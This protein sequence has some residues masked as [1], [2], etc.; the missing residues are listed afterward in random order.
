MPI[1]SFLEFHFKYMVL[2]AHQINS[3]IPE[4]PETKVFNKTLE[5]AQRRWR[6]LR[7]CSWLD[8][9]SMQERGQ[10]LRIGLNLCL[11]VCIPALTIIWKLN[12]CILFNKIN[13]LFQYNSFPK[14][15]SSSDSPSH[16]CRREKQLR[17][18]VSWHDPGKVSYQ[19]PQTAKQNAKLLHKILS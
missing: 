8:L 9:K 18:P 11:P 1:V 15:L 5:K 13:I 2:P 12:R 7:V 16:T 17:A 3:Q 14:A 6:D 4:L 19:Q 10:G